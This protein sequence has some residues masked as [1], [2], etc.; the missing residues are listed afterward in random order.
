[1]TRH[2]VY[3]LQLEGGGPIKVGYS[4]NPKMRMANLKHSCPYPLHFIGLG[5]GK[6]S[7]EKRFHDALH[8]H[9]IHGEWYRPDSPVLQMINDALKNGALRFPKTT[10]KGLDKNI[11]RHKP[12]KSD[13]YPAFVNYLNLRKI[14]LRQLGRKAGISHMTIR[15]ILAGN[16]KPSLDTVEAIYRATAGKVWLAPKP[17][18]DGK[19]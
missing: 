10:I 1:M 14:T 15:N 8:N 11:R 18:L 3:F 2:T 4:Q 12:Y 9:C 7:D 6:R 16:S 13:E 19:Q 17:K 5:N